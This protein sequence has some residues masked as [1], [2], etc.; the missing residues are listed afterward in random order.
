MMGCIEIFL[1]GYFQVRKDGSLL[2]GFESN[3]VRAL[4]SYL[5][6]ENNQVHPRE[7][8]AELLW[9]DHPDGFALTNLRWVVHNLREV[10]VDQNPG[11][12]NSPAAFLDVQ[13]DYIQLN[14]TSEI[15]IDAIHFVNLIKDGCHDNDMTR[16]EQAIG[17][18]RGNFL[19]GLNVKH[20]TQFEEWVLLQQERFSQKHLHAL[21]L[22]TNHRIESGDFEMAK[23]YARRQLILE[24]WKEEAHQQLMRCLAASGERS[25]ALAQ[26][27][28]CRRALQ[29]ELGVQP[30]QETILLYQLINRGE[31][32][33]F[34]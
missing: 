20:S 21:Y 3:K 10:L 16:L 22:L 15:W 29:E 7:S 33:G 28:N 31:L 34:N 18:Y 5:A 13:R 24:P 12:G 2:S 30:S 23:E 25:E 1:L 6:I 9:P 11:S 4:L 14:L 8:L 17:L 27:E 26:F 19:D 32:K